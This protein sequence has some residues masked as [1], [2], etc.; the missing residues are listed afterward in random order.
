MKLE[1]IIDVMEQL[2]P[3]ETALGFDNVG[4]LVGTRRKDIKKVLIALD[5]TAAV[6]NEAVS[7]GADLI[8]TH[9]PIMFSAIKRVLPDDPVSGIVYELIRND[10]AMFAAHTNLDAAEGGVNTAL[11]NVLGLENIEIIPPENIMRIGSLK[12]EMM[13]DDF[14]ALAEDRLGIKVQISGE[15]RCIKRVAVMGGAGGSDYALAHQYGADVYLT[16]ECKHSQAVEASVLNLPIITAGH[17]QTE[18]VVLK[19]LMNYLKQRITGVEFLLS[20]ANKPVF[21]NI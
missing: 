18:A 2:A 11:C 13:L 12:K 10:I 9:H 19:P 1:G 16:G 4:L 8:L 5:C 21:R 7:I 15:N 3:H 14:A 20:K 6:V 17:H